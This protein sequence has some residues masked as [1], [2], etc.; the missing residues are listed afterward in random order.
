MRRAQYKVRNFFEREA[1]MLNPK[2]STVVPLGVLS[3][4]VL[5]LVPARGQEAGPQPMARNLTENKF[6]NFPNFPTCVTGA[7]QQGDPAHGAS[8]ILVKSSAGCS[9]PWHWHTP[10]EQLMMVAGTGHLEIKGQ[11]PV[12]LRAGG[13]ALM[14][15]HHV[16]QLHCPGPC[17]LFVQASGP[18]DLHY[19][20]SGGNEIAAEVALKAVKE[21]PAPAPAA[22]P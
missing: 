9:V 3:I 6:V 16:H 15:S 7:V 14:P 5:G 8:V 10:D 17:T 21:K 22:S 13:Y 20:D 2:Y 12:T 11:K 18:F 1:W 19:V 4:F